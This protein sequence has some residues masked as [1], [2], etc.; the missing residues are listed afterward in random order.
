MLWLLLHLAFGYDTTYDFQGRE[1]RIY[2][3]KTKAPLIVHFHGCNQNTDDFYQ[4][5]KSAN[6]KPAANIMFVEQ[7]L[8]WHSIRCWNWF[9]TYNQT[10]FD[11]SE[12]DV[13][14]QKILAIKQELNASSLHLVGFSSGAGLVTNLAFAYADK[15]D[16]AFIHSGPAF[17]I[18]NSSLS[19]LDLMKTGNTKKNIYHYIPNGK[20]SLSRVFLVQGTADQV[21]HPNN[22]KL[23]VEQFRYFFNIQSS[24]TNMTKQI[25][26]SK[27]Y[28]IH[29]WQ[30]PIAH[31]WAGGN[32]NGRYSAPD[33]EDALGYYYSSVV[34]I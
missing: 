19:A 31:E 9:Y 3:T 25:L 29:V 15:I 21:V 7:N 6:I 32:A 30:L 16:S 23:L 22:Q 1:Y 26:K 12:S 11:G 5:T 4:L 27:K 24:M 20:K 13:V 2:S 17:G 28:Q 8:F 14:L 33:T 34:G 10:V 18:A